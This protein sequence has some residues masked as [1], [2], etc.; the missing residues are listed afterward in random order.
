MDLSNPMGARYWDEIIVGKYRI[1]L[2]WLGQEQNPS[3]SGPS[4]NAGIGVCQKNTTQQ[5]S[6]IRQLSSWVVTNIG[7]GPYD[8]QMFTR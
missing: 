2:Q 1:G 3:L 8:H 5:V 7:M 6:D 4:N